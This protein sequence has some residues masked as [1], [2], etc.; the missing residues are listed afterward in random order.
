MSEFVHLHLHSEYSLLSST[1]RISEIPKQAKASG[2]KAVALT[3]T[4]VMFGAVDFAKAC[5]KEEIKP[6]IGCEVYVAKRRMSDKDVNVD[7]EVYRLVLLCKNSTGYKNLIYLVSHGYIDG[8]FM[9]IPR[10]D[11]EILHD[12]SDGL[13]CISSH[14]QGYI[15]KHIM[16]GEYNKAERYA[17]ELNDTFEKGN[18]YL[19]IVNH[20]QSKDET[21]NNA[22]K[23]IAENTGIPMVATN[24]VFY[25]KKD[26][27]DTLKVLC[28]IRDGKKL[29]DGSDF[30]FTSNEYYFK[31]G[32]EM[33]TLFPG[34]EEAIQNTV[35]IADMCE[36]KFEFGHTQLPRY[37]PDN[38]DS[39]EKY[40]REIAY[41]GLEKHMDDGSLVMSH[42]NVSEEYHDRLEYELSVINRMGYDEYFL[43]VWDFVNHAR[44][45][46]IVVG[47]GRGSGAGSL[48]AFLI[49]I[50]EIDPIRYGLLFERFLNPER[51]SMPDFDIDFE[52]ERREEAISYVREKYGYDRISQIV[53]FNTLAARSAIKDVG[54][55]MNLSYG[56]TDSIS[57]FI[58]RSVNHN[59][60]IDEAL[61][62]SEDLKY[63]Y[64]TNP[65]ITDLLDYARNIEGMP[66]S[67]SKHAAGIVITDGPVTDY[68]PVIV[69][70]GMVTQ[71]SKDPLTDL[72]LLKFDFLAVRDLTIIGKTEKMVRNKIPSFDIT[73]I[74]VD[75]KKTYEMISSGKSD[76]IFQLESSGMRKTLM[77]LKPAAIDDIMVALALYRPGPKDAIPRYIEARRNPSKI[78]YDIPALS[79]ILD[80]TYGCIVYQEQ[81]MQIFREIAGYTFGHADIVRRAISKKK[82]SVISGERD[83]FIKG[84]L[85]R[86]V[87]E[88]SAAKLFESILSFADY[89]FNK[90][91]SAAYA[92]VSYRAAYLKANYPK[93]FWA[94]KLSFEENTDKYSKYVSDCR[95]QNIKILP[96]DINKSFSDFTVEGGGLRFGLASL[97]GMGRVFSES[98]VTEREKN[99]PY[100]SLDDFM[101]R[102]MTCGLINRQTECLIKV[103]AFDS[104]G[105][106]RSS[107]LAV[108]EKLYRK[109]RNEEAESGQVNL[110]DNPEADNTK[111]AETIY[112]SV[113]ELSDVDRLEMEKEI[114]G[115]YLTGSPLD[116]Y[117]DSIS[118]LSAKTI[119]DIKY[120]IVSDDSSDGN[121]E[122]SDEVTVV[123]IVRG[124]NAKITHRGENMAYAT[125]EDDTSSIEVVVYPRVY[126]KYAHLLGTG[127]CVA[128]RGKISK[129]DGE[130]LKISA[131]SIAKIPANSESTGH[132]RA[133]DN[134]SAMDMTAVRKIFLRVPS[135]KS[136]EYI[137][138]KAFCEIFFGRTPCVFYFSDQGKYSDRQIV[139]ECNNFTI[140]ELVK[141]LGKDNV[142]LR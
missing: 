44:E 11:D 49:G 66:R 3:D 129:R 88:S 61:N 20:G 26:E 128:V 15:S 110:F 93:E 47:P 98:V 120:S 107:L 10:I 99:G 132:K 16:S 119:A 133:A 43:I 70:E 1:C 38:G 121:A 22:V 79:K 83:N 36:F 106:Q 46:S 87:D 25:L 31:S 28:C 122:D 86:G 63:Q 136:E 95:E 142:A 92:M 123:G 84:A 30:G 14:N 102:Q 81:V 32:D 131:D 17:L 74:P 40:L 113:P 75:D 69:D 7:S 124:L 111:E 125:L 58:P 100:K 68:V 141:L 19:E 112:P 8:L 116:Q 76:G 65:E 53:T 80:S 101:R 60:T 127:V 78:K 48:V 77:Q 105:I 35:K 24:D 4:G 34:F 96:P 18:F 85:E 117:S 130:N 138:S 50:V 90:S 42:G 114:S 45:N 12:H 41:R 67:L 57:K 9:G 89:A 27:A 33:E 109:I 13:V 140:G 29:S 55:V 37:T 72:G 39:P 59:V 73:K 21:I 137:R 23:K 115:I 118:Y 97:K 91:H 103:G 5:E 56:I 139:V 94:S 52:D 62:T 6:I 104:L 54:R 126:G 2:Q 108:N 135:E 64:E 71:Y 134:K 82:Q 51:V